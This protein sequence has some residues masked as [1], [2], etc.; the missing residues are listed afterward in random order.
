[1]TYN[2]T[3]GD[4]QPAH[5]GWSPLTSKVYLIKGNGARED[6][7]QH[8]MAFCDQSLPLPRAAKEAIAMAIGLTL[9]P[10]E[11]L[12]PCMPGHCQNHGLDQRACTER[13]AKDELDASLMWSSYR[14][15]PTATGCGRRL[16]ASTKACGYDGYWC[17]CAMDGA[18]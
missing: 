2:R 6:W 18:A 5:L 15:P 13:R 16:G 17:G 1:M 7:T 10:I 14:L 4:R 3:R 8:F 11:D 9:P 12:P